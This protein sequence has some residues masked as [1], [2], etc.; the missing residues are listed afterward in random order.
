[1]RATE[2]MADLDHKNP[3]AFTWSERD[4]VRERRESD[5]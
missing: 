5:G 4:S 1:M 2:S 3:K